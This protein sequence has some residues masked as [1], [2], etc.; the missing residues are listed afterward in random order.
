VTA[1]RVGD[2]ALAALFYAARRG[3]LDEAFI[4]R[5]AR[6]PRGLLEMAALSGIESEPHQGA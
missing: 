3:D 6:T 2:H 4:Y 5:Q 1:R